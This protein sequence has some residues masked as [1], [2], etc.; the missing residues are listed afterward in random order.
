MRKTKWLIIILMTMV[1]STSVADESTIVKP[2]MIVSLPRPGNRMILV[3]DAVRVNGRNLAIIEI[4]AKDREEYKRWSQNK[5][6]PY[7]Y[8]AAWFSPDWKLIEI[9]YGVYGNMADFAP[10]YHVKKASTGGF[11]PRFPRIVVHDE[12]TDS[13]PYIFGLPNKWVCLGQDL[14]PQKEYPIPFTALD[15]IGYQD[16]LLWIGGWYNKHGI[17]GFNIKKGELERSVITWSEI[18]KTLKEEKIQNNHTV[19]ENSEESS[20]TL[21][22]AFLHSTLFIW[23]EH[24]PVFILYRWPDLQL[25]KAYSLR[26]EDFPRDLPPIGKILT[27]QLQSWGNKVIGWL[28]LLYPMT[29]QQFQLEEPEL[30]EMIRRNW[31]KNR[32]E[33]LMPNTVIGNGSKILMLVFNPELGVQSIAPVFKKDKEWRLMGTPFVIAHTKEIWVTVQ[34]IDRETRRS[35]IARLR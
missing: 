24:P 23:V 34:E 31:G 3:Q 29:F 28:N 16:G 8:A 13:C 7:Q 33:A 1:G 14:Q 18:E 17:H 30:A 21:E 10:P 19:A 26:R 27:V 25:I 6:G 15:Y 11:L 9:G 2:G 5:G 22:A 35:G 20:P 12:T 32:S 4:W